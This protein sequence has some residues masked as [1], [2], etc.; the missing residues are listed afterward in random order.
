LNF[1]GITKDIFVHQKQLGNFKEGE[2]VSFGVPL[3]ETTDFDVTSVSHNI[4]APPALFFGGWAFVLSPGVFL[5]NVIRSRKAGTGKDFFKLLEIGFLVEY[6]ATCS[7]VI[8][9]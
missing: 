8:G 5:G 7:R 9:A 3:K 1:F 4:G 2:N 6:R